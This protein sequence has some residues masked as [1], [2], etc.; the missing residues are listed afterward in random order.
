ME[1]S[2]CK[3]DDRVPN[4]TTNLAKLRRARTYSAKIQQSQRT[5][6]G[7]YSPEDLCE[8]CLEGDSAAFTLK[9]L[10]ITVPEWNGG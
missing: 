7:S 10:S 8:R 5:N 6:F 4:E 3:L 2:V 1:E 9:A